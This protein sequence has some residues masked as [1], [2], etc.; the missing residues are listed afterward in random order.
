M[1]RPPGLLFAPGAAIC[2]TLAG[3]LSA[4]RLHCLVRRR[5]DGEQMTGPPALR[6]VP[7]GQ[8]IV[9]V[10][11]DAVLVPPPDGL[12]A[13]AEPPGYLGP[14]HSRYL[15]APHQALRE[16]V[17]L[18]A[19]LDALSR[20][21]AGLPQGLARA[22]PPSVHSWSWPNPFSGR[23]RRPARTSRVCGPFCVFRP[24]GRNRFTGTPPPYSL[25]LIS[26]CTVSPG[27]QVNLAFCQFRTC[28]P[29]LSR[30]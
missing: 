13:G 1:S 5:S 27:A 2:G 4:L 16:V 12:G 26:N 19:V 25:T 20:H 8:E 18:S 22:L 17:G 21:L 11:P 29:E 3:I 10:G 14:R 23:D 6:E 28:L 30:A 15:P 9:G 7:W 24:R